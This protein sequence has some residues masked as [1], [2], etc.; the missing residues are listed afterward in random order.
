MDDEY[1][2]TALQEQNLGPKYKN[3]EINTL[4]KSINDLAAIFNDISILVIE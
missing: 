3:E 1:F 2:Q 4:V